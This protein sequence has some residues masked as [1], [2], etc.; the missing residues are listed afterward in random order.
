MTY[1]ALSID[2]VTGYDMI[3]WAFLCDVTID[4]YVVESDPKLGK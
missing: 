3:G 1:T 4:I 2:G